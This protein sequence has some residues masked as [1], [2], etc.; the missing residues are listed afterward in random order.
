[1]QEEWNE[2]GHYNFTFYAFFLYHS[3]FLSPS[4]P[5]SLVLFFSVGQFNFVVVVVAV[6]HTPLCIQ[7]H[8]L[9]IHVV[10]ALISPV[11]I[12]L[13]HWF[14]GQAPLHLRTSFI[15]I[16]LVGAQFRFHCCLRA[17]QKHT[18]TYEK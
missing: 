10:H 15:H 11:R 12:S 6:R 16:Y 18:Y 9:A 13:I 4:L 7:I 8:H 3:L 2:K 17:P 5:P 1:M 14:G